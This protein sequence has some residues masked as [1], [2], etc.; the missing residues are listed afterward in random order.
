VTD[1]QK[2]GVSLSIEGK[3]RT[4]I[5]GLVRLAL[6]AVLIGILFVATAAAGPSSCT[7]G[8]SSVGPAVLVNGRLATDRSDLSAHTQACLRR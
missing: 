5:S 8:A 2:E 4:L 7:H 3:T 1:T 6:V